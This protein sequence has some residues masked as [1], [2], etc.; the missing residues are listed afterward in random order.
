MH[1]LVYVTTN[2]ENGK[3]YIG[4]HST[5]NLNDNYC[6]S[7]VW[8]LRAKKAKKKLFTRV[9]KSCQT[10]EEAYKQEYE[11]IVA[12][13]ECWPD[14]CMN[15][16][17]GG[18]GFSVSYPSNRRGENAPMYGKKHSEKTRLRLAETSSSR[19]GE[20]H[21]M[22]GK[23]HNE[24]SRKKMS[25]THRSIGHLRGKKVKSL[26]TGKVYLSLSDAARD[27]ANDVT[28]RSCIRNC[29]NG[30][31]KQSYGQKWIFIEE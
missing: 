6:G 8:V 30:K 17:D 7:G 31:T 22:Y 24:D 20:N 11:I 29:I 2:I 18:V 27:V 14:L 5:K 12:A 28:A 13:K 23:K 15:M 9:V 21:H 1:H 4:K 10:E 3:F 16:S 25:E 26:T 19:R